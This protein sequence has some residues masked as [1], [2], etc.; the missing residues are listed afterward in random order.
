LL[1][2]FF[3]FKFCDVAEVVI[4]HIKDVLANSGYEQNIKMRE[5]KRLSTFLAT[6][7]E[8]NRESGDFVNFV[9]LFSKVD[10]L[11]F[12]FQ[13]FFCCHFEIKDCQLYGRKCIKL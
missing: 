1:R 8:P 12:I 4:I 6:L 7:L 11:I 13:I 10:N 9:N 5:F 2:V 3:V